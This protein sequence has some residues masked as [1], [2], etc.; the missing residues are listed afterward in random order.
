MCTLMGEDSWGIFSG[1]L[2]MHKIF[3]NHWCLLKSHSIIFKN[4]KCY[5]Q[6]KMLLLLGTTMNPGWASTTHSLVYFRITACLLPLYIFTFHGCI[7]IEMQQL[8]W[9]SKCCENQELCWC[10]AIIKFE[11][12]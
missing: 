1:P 4:Y 11:K 5:E 10:L 2:L 9:H 6:I 8:C 7:F 12:M 3:F